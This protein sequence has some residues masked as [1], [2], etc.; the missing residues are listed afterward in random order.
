[1]CWQCGICVLYQIGLKYMHWLERSMHLCF[2]RWFDDVT[3]INFRFRRLVTWSSPHGRAASSHKIWY[4]YLYP[5]WS[6]WH[7]FPEIQD[8]GR[9]HL[10]FSDYVNLAIR[11]FWQCRIRVL[12]KIGLKYMH[13]LLR[14]THL[15][16]RRSFDDV[17]R[18]NFRFQFLVTWSSAHG[19]D[20][21][22]CKIWCIY[23]YPVRRH[24]HFSE[25]QDG[26][27]RH[28]GFLD[29]VNLAI[30]VCWQCGICVLYQIWLKYLHSLLRSTPL[31]FRRSFDDVTRI[32]F[33]FRLLVTRSSAHGR[34]TSYCKIWCRYL[35]SMRSYWHFTEIKDGLDLQ[36]LSIW[37]L[38]RVGSV[39]FVFCTKFG[40][41]TCYSHWDRRTYASDPSFDDVTRIN[42]RFRFLVTWSSARRRDAS[43]HVIWCKISL[44]SPKLLTFFR[45]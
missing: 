38:R 6:Y 15:C 30:R 44:S 25:I 35:Y 5:V 9:R 23:L 45:N 33:R 1:V 19:R 3:R 8:G 18:I 42:F 14:S 16:F 41:N 39:V 10:G 2:R 21:S 17:T 28:L 11:V 40:P 27:R 12:Y 13:W 20:A 43:F 22:S 34:N 4:I 36:F 24:W 31:C 26:G 32:N 7:F 37:P 29:Y